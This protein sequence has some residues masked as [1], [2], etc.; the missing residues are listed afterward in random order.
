MRR[1]KVKHI[2]EARRAVAVYVGSTVAW[3]TNQAGDSQLDNTLPPTG[4]RQ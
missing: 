2:T 3:A 4:R 1:R